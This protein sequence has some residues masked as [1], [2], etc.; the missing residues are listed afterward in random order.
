MRILLLVPALLVL[1]AVSAQTRKIPAESA[2][3][4]VIVFSSGARIERVSAI[5]IQAGRTEI[6]FAGLS[7][8][9]DQQSVQLKAD[10][11]I[12][13]LSVR[14]EKDYLTNRKIDQQ[15]QDFIDKINA[16][17]D[18]ITLDEK[19]LEVCKNEE[20]ILAKNRDLG[21][22]AGVKTAD[23]KEALDFQRQR[24]TE[25]Y[26]RELEITRRLTAQRED[27]A[28][29]NDQLKVFSKKKDSVNYIVTALV[30]SKTAQTVNF[31]LLYNIKDAGWYPTYDVRVTDISQPL[32]VL[33]NANVFQRSGETWKNISLQLSTGNPGDNAT[34]SQ[35]SPWL[36]G[37]YDPAAGR[38]SAS[39]LSQLSG[40]VTNDKGEP[41]AGATINGVSGT[42]STDNNGY[43]KLNNIPQN[44]TISV[45]YIG[46]T[47]R[48]AVFNGGYMAVQLKEAPNT[49]DEVV[50]VGYA[51]L[52]GRLA[53]LSILPVATTTQY[54]PTATVYRIDDKYT[55]E[56]DGK[57]TT[58]GIRQL[59]VPAIYDYYSAPKVDPTAFLT[60]RI[61]GWQDLDL[62]S[63]EASLYLEGAYLGK[64]YIDL[65]ATADT[66]SLSLGKDPGIHVIRRLLKEYSTRKFIGSNRTDSREY[67][68]VVRNT[69]KASVNITFV[70]QVPVSTTRDISV[71]DVKAAEAQFDK[72]N[73]EVKWVMTL[74]PGQEKKLGISYSVKYPKDR[75]VVLE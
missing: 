44:S 61:T 41:L 22:Q 12:T 13:L 11:N 8:Q 46:Y 24:L 31:K 14:T 48:T 45:S 5:N 74:P 3:Q 53:G 18:K 60:A 28:R 34:P 54:Q 42:T 52:S 35:L 47:E 55:L 65:A 69:K 23:L 49:L 38:G 4:N 27:L 7:N 56:S 16:L 9:L 43:F 63:G 68:L 72:N 58:I 39:T 59:E 33:M 10:A 30:D 67:E 57:T 40:R 21:G 19:L 15:E 75:K 2:I 32:A 17:R 36:L 62:Q 26:N 64:T 29:N 37:F 71:E 50:V 66:L 25:V 70:D 1:A 6:V 51:K 73:G 20:D